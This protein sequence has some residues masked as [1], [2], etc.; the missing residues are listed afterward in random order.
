MDLFVY[1]TLTDR[2]LLH[3]LTGRSFTLQPARLHDYERIVPAR[4]Y[5]FIRPR[6]QHWVD[7]FLI[8]SVDEASLR[9]LDEYEAEGNLYHRTMV[10]VQAGDRTQSCAAYVV[11][12]KLVTEDGAW[13]PPHL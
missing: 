4:G 9:Q 1:G 3:A 6:P 7:G 13:K 11:N 5:P 8:R 10:T 2:G 12:G